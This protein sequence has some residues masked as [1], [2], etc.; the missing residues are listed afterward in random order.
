[1]KFVF[2]LLILIFLFS[3]CGYTIA[4]ENLKNIDSLPEMEKAAA[5]LILAKSNYTI[6]FDLADEYSIKAMLLAKKFSQKEEY[7]LANKYLGITDYYRRNFDDALKHYDKALKAFEET[8]NLKEKANVINNIALIYSDRNDFATAIEYHKRSK[9]IREELNDT[10]GIIGSLNNIGNLYQKQNNFDKAIEFYHQ[11]I[12]I[13]QLVLPNMHFPNIYLSLAKCEN[14]MGKTNDA[15]E[16]YK[17]AIEEA[18]INNDVRSLIISII[19]LSNVY[20]SIGSSEKS[21]SGLM[22]AF[23]LAREN[24]LRY[25]EAVV[26][27]NLGNIYFQTNQYKEANEFYNYALNIYKQTDDKE[28]IINALINIALCN[29]H[30]NNADSALY[31]YKQARIISEETNKPEQLAKTANYL[32]KYYLKTNEDKLAVYWFNQALKISETNNLLN[33]NYLANYNMGLYWDKIQSYDKAIHFY[34]IA[35]KLAKELQSV[36]FQKDVTE[37]LWITYEKQNNFSK[38]FSTLK[39]FNVLKD[40]I[41][42][43]EKQQQIREIEGK[44]NL[45]LKENQIASQRQIILQQEKILKQEQWYKIYIASVAILL[46]ILLIIILN[47]KKIRQQKEKSELIR[48]NLTVERDLLQMQ[49][50]PH[51][52]FN[53]LNSIQSFIS[54]NDS[55]KAE[56]FLSKFARLMRY[57]LDS[58]SEKWVDFSEELI[59]IELNLEIEK[60]R[61]NDKFEYEIIIDEAIDKDEIQLPPMLLQPFIENAVKHGLRPKQSRGFLKIGFSLKDDYLFCYI[62]DDGIGREAAGKNKKALSGHISKGVNLTKKRLAILLPKNTTINYFR[63]NDLVDKNGL[64]SGTRVELIIPIKYF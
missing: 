32:G 59:A 17:K 40:S 57:Y 3:V 16:N 21:I 37:S 35:E 8:G 20:R 49:M 4:Q 13:A 61:L 25:L 44:L 33:D 28:G 58:S 30:L 24:K 51:F 54:E 19:N 14:S 43:D 6:N 63:I 23:N 29:E 2:K 18:T 15:I 9:N 42:N 52:I 46:I 60:L 53:A 38:A 27:L 12:G 55:F 56:L 11:A 26:K 64:P 10:E 50:N 34:I 31:N 1:M 62:E 47:R 41:F 36:V 48:Q 7:G 39:Q 22:K 45:N 5:L